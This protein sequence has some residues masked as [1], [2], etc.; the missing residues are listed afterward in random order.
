MPKDAKRQLTIKFKAAGDKQLTTAIKR[1]AAAQRQLEHITKKQS[2]T[3]RKHR[4]RVK[5]NTIAVNKLQ[6]IIGIYRNKM[7]LASFAIGI[8]T[9][10]LVNQ[11]KAFGK[12]EES[13]QRIASVFGVDAALALDEYSSK[14]QE[15]STFGDEH[16]NVVMAQLGAF[17]AS[18]DQTKNLTKATIDLAAGM[19]LDLNTAALLMAKSFG[20]STNALSRYGIELDATMNQNEKS[21]AIVKQVEEKYGGLAK[22]LAQTTSGQLQ[23]A[24]NAFGDFAENIGAVLAPAILMAAK[25]L[26]SF[27]EAL[28]TQTIK[29][30]GIQLG[31]LT[32]AFGYYT[33][34]VN[35]AAT[36]TTAFKLA[37]TT[38][39]GGM[40]KFGGA[41][42]A[43]GNFA[44]KNPYL[45]LITATISAIGWMTNWFGLV[46]ENDYILDEHGNKIKR[47]TE[48][49]K[50]FME[51]QAESILKLQDKLDALAAKNEAEKYALEVGRKLNNL[52]LDMIWAIT[53]KNEEL[54]KEQTIQKAIQS[55]ISN[56]ITVQK[57]LREEILATAEANL[58]NAEAEKTD[59]ETTD[60]RIKKLKDLVIQ[61]N[62]WAESRIKN[63]NTFAQYDTDLQIKDFKGREMEAWTRAIIENNSAMQEYEK[64]GNKMNQTHK[65]HRQKLGDLEKVLKN[66]NIDVPS[67]FT[68]LETSWYGVG[69]ESEAYIQQFLD[70][71][72]PNWA[73][74]MGHIEGLI[75]SNEDAIKNY[76]IAVKEAKDKVNEAI[77][78][79]EKSKDTLEA[80]YELMNARFSENGKYIKSIG[81]QEKS[82]KKLSEEEKLIIKLGGEY[83]AAM[84]K[85][86]EDYVNGAENAYYYA[87]A[88]DDINDKLEKQKKKLEEAAKKAELYAHAQQVAADALSFGSEMMQ[89]RIN[90]AKETADVQISEIDR[91]L[92]HELEALRESFAYKK[93][94]DKKKTE[95][96]KAITDKADQEKKKAREKA[97]KDMLKAFKIKQHLDAGEAAMSTANAVMKT[98]S[99]GMGFF[100]IGLAAVVAAMGAKQIDMIYKQKPPKM[101]YGGLIGGNRHSQGGTMIEAERG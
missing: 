74:K 6:S 85:Q 63:F 47:M 68:E 62:K 21:A 5:K 33:L 89:Q 77:T 75:S 92:N 7:L 44:M 73:E 60:I 17:G 46:K 13:V 50:K 10:V 98:L 15:A 41:L 52:E 18:I 31:I 45:I 76:G 4:H 26:K 86:I 14:L 58:R 61:D 42:L 71:Y 32:T 64:A 54:Q 59:L 25:G 66:L 97:N 12:Q 65:E 90:E 100:S 2:K 19:Q 39:L 22:Q 20:S 80:K 40:K 72:F 87:L 78:V 3:L 88:I 53:S 48:E 49:E 43:I 84:T 29:K 9:K 94:S 37:L 79:E 67:V 99:H 70:E 11:V 51:S 34:S 35:A 28:D 27:T 23:Q 57:Q 82:L 83:S 95:M 16:I 55:L 1:L 96:E 30:I 56:N 81:E 101:Q 38:L 8:V 69:D 91:V 93:A 36:S 24:S